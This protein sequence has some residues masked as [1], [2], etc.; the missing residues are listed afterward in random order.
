MMRLTSITILFGLLLGV[1]FG[2]AAAGGVPQTAALKEGVDLIE[3]FK[4]IASALHMDVWWLTIL[5]FWF[6]WALRRFL[7]FVKVDLKKPPQLFHVLSLEKGWWPALRDF[8]WGSVAICFAYTVSGLALWLA[9]GSLPELPWIVFGP[10]YGLG[11]IILYLILKRL[12]RR[13]A[14]IRERLKAD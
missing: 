9:P 4:T 6:V 12:G 13:V 10:V 3:G 2:Y 14:W 11:A 5:T 7:N 1:F 8:V